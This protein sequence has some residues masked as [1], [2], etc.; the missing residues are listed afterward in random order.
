MTNETLSEIVVPAAAWG[1]A[2]HYGRSWAME[3]AAACAHLDAM[4][5]IDLKAHMT[6]WE[7]QM[8]SADRPK[9]RRLSDGRVIEADDKPYRMRGSVALLS[10]SG[11]TTK[12]MSS[13]SYLFGGTATE[14]LC[15]ELREAREDPAVSSAVLWIDSPGGSTDGQTDLGNAITAFATV[16]PIIAYV[17]DLCASAGLW[18][19]CCCSGIIAGPGAWLGSIGV[20][21]VIRDS[22]RAAENDGVR[23]VMRSTGPVKG[24]G[25]PGTAITDTH[26][27]EMDRVNSVQF[28]QFVQVVAG[29][30]GIDESAVRAIA[31]GQMYDAQ[32]ALAKGL[33]D[34]I[35]SLDDAIASLQS[36][37]WPDDITMA[38]MTGGEETVTMANLLKDL[39]AKI[40]GA[41][42]TE[43]EKAAAAALE[44]EVAAKDAALD[45]NAKL[46]EQIAK[47][48]ETGTEDAAKILQSEAQAFAL[49]LVKEGRITAAESGDLID[50][51]V[52]AKADD[53]ADGGERLAKLKAREGKRPANKMHAELIPGDASVE[54]KDASETVLK[55][56]LSREATPNA[57]NRGDHEGLDAPTN[58]NHRLITKPLSAADREAAVA[59]ARGANGNGRGN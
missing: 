4:A 34:G 49:G 38:G 51:Y 1:L 55:L 18:S 9:Y 14:L 29:G 53:T 20:Y 39:V 19:A 59:R 41:A 13:M 15:Q 7:A 46:K 5:T 44:A 16:K 27:A 3:G 48:Q 28:A 42:K 43:P 10:I 31:T 30:R 45:E 22:S 6:A 32:D 58:D 35:M 26:I 52:Q 8:A 33:I 47:L 23:I 24:M 40:S 36:G 50:A 56:L 17:P 21:R 12:R 2:A 57:D 11:P 25:V 37:E 54:A